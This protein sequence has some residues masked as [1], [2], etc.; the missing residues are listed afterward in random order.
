MSDVKLARLRM[1]HL[2][3]QADVAKAC[4]V[5]QSAVSLWECGR[6]RPCRKHIKRLAKLYKCSADDIASAVDFTVKNHAY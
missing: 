6:S 5:S 1:Q 4:D 3:T 2:F